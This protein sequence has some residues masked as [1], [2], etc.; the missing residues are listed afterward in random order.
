MY[1]HLVYGFLYL[2]SLL[3]SFILYG[4]SDLVYP[5]LYYVFGYRKKVVM[6]NLSIALPIIHRFEVIDI[7]HQGGRLLS[8]GQTPP[9]LSRMLKETPPI[10]SAG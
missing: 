9:D 2:I 8:G 10:Q 4:L 3:P 6:Y 5:L 1:S 7:D